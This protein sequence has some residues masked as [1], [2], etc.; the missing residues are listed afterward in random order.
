MRPALLLLA[1]LFTGCTDPIDEAKTADTIEAWEAYLA[2]PEATG[3]NKLTAESRLEEL[4]AAKA[5]SSKLIADYDALIKRFP[6]A[7]D[8][9]KRQKT[10]VE[11]SLAE[12]ET[13]NT[14]EGWQKFVTD[15]PKADGALV[16]QA[17][18]RIAMAEY[19]PKLTITELKIEQVNLAED[20]KGPKDGWGFSV[21][22]TNNGDKSIN[23]LNM[24]LSI[25]DPSGAATNPI[26]YP[27]CASTFNVPM[28][29]EFYK[30]IEPGQ[31]RHW[32][33]TTGEVPENF[34]TTPAG[35]VVPI[36]IRFVGEN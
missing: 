34:A 10:R 8:V 15:N 22:I 5:D 33:Y 36:T 6:K 31:T 4:L 19:V 29:E 32:V 18:N 1:F 24:Q 16:K 7:R 9:K 3:S 28:V 11:L 30:P 14:P 21:D 25:T 20:P 13:T 17:K 23:Y 12:A 27:A 2:K 26:P 35:K